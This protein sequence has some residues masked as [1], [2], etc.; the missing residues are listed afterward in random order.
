MHF[1][2]DFYEL[3]QIDTSLQVIISLALIFFLAFLFTR[4]TKLIHLPNVT[5]YMLTGIIIGPYVFNLIPNKIITEMS[6]INDIGLG[7]IGFSCGRYFNL[8]IVK[9]NG[10]KPIIISLVETTLTT[11]AVFLLMLAFNLP[12]AICLL[13]GLLA[14]GTSASS[15]VM[16]IR[17]YNCK[18]NYVDYIVEL[19]ALNNLFVLITFSIVL[20][21]LNQMMGFSSSLSLWESILIP[22]LSNVLCL[23]V[24]VFF[25]FILAKVFI[26]RSR[27][28][29]NRLILTVGTILVLVAVNSLCKLISKTN[30][31][32]S[33]LSTMI[34]A[35]TYMNFSNDDSLFSQV[36]DFCA[37]FLLIFFVL[38]GFKLDFSSLASVGWVGLIYFLT[39][40]VFKYL[41]LFLGTLI[42][43]GDKNLRYFGGFNMYPQAGV[44]IGSAVMAA[45]LLIMLNEVEWANKLQAIVI[46]T[47]VLFEIIGPVLSKLALKKSGTLLEN[48]IDK[49][50]RVI[51][52]SSIF[53][54]K[55]EKALTE[56]EKLKHQKLIDLQNEIDKTNT[57]IHTKS[58]LDFINKE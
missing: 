18:G 50:S 10:Y 30:I 2:E 14:A 38:S 55:I 6:F 15:T 22:L 48:N 26:K 27:S 53:H 39:R 12:L 36:N 46:T 44:A 57:Y 45:N 34:L 4:L 11:T 47:A 21:F 25:G 9:K 32:S 8:K 49:S 28:K 52:S 31:V 41:G 5:A 54:D 1:L 56:E 19:I 16:T 3:Y 33:L 42:V 23:I 43:K 13:L 40:F 7:I 17:Q 35:A 58:Y 20:G 51:E 37:P 29:D 24:S